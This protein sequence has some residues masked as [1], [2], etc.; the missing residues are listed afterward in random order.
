MKFAFNVAKL[1]IWARNGSCLD[2]CQ[3]A[4]QTEQAGHTK[5]VIAE[6]CQD[7]VGH[8]SKFPAPQ[9]FVSDI[10][11]LQTKDGFPNIAEEPWGNCPDSQMS[12]SFLQFIRCLLYTFTVSS[13]LLTQVVLY[14]SWF[15]AGVEDEM[16]IAAVFLS[17]DKK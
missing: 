9:K 5:K 1:A 14:P 6:L 7:K 3:Y 2:C 17:Y 12:L 8:H 16:I 11:G 4:V 13:T 10:L 15:S